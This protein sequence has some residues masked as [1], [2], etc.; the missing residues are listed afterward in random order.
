VGALAGI[1]RAGQG[2]YR[3]RGMF[4]KVQP[5]L[6]DKDAQVRASAVVAAAAV[7]PKGATA[8]IP[9]ICRKEQNRLVL[10]ACA[11]A[12]ALL[13]G[14]E[15]LKGLL[16]LAEH[17]EASVKMAALTGLTR[18]REP[19]AQKQVGA[20]AAS[21]DPALRLLALEVAEKSALE[22]ALGDAAL[23]VRA[24]ALERLARPGGMRVLP[25][26][27]ELL[28]GTPAPG[29]KVRYAEAWLRATA[30]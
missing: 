22:Q 2:G 18:R 1:T 30:S 24:T 27:L 19:E 25:R 23:E 29:E 21:D 17:P 26:F 13:P 6:K 11:N 7:E 10:E 12:F 28:V 15:P 3:S 20:L 14:A 4:Y 5:L 8:E 16:K 9:V